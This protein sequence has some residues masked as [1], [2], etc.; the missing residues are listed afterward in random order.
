MRW[1]HFVILVQMP[2]LCATLAARSLLFPSGP[3]IC[4]AR[5]ISVFGT[6]GQVNNIKLSVH[7]VVFCNPAT[8]SSRHEGIA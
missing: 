2:V 1:A 8:H 7:N 5:V 6:T 3:C 4:I